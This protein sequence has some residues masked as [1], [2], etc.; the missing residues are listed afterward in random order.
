VEGQTK[1]RGRGEREMCIDSGVESGAERKRNKLREKGE[2]R[3]DG[4][5]S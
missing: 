1:G 4:C 5:S 3:S 2:S